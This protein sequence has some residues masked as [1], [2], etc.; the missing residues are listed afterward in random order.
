MS[1]PR[2]VSGIQPSWRLH[3]GNY[4]G[5]LKNLPH[6]QNS[7]QYE[8]FFFLA[9]LH[10]LTET[11]SPADKKRQIL[12]LAADLFAA[13]LDP[14]KATIFQQSAVESHTVLSWIFSTITPMG[15]LRRMTQFKD[16][17]GSADEDSIITN[18]GL[19]TYPVLM[20]SDILMYNPSF[21]PVGSDQLQHLE[22]TRTIARKFNTKFGELFIEPQPLLTATPRIMSLKD[23]TK[24]M[25]KSTPAGCLFV[26]DEPDVIMEKLKGAV[27][28]SG[29]EITYDPLTKPAIAN[30]IDIV[31]GVTGKTTAEVA[32]EYSG[33]SYSSFKTAVA[34]RIADA[35]AHHRTMKKELLADPDQMTAWLGAGAERAEEVAAMQLDKVKEVIGINLDN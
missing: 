23:P 32:T 27:T 22:L 5:V 12:E 26:D 3:V 17:S 25:S 11:Y 18:V 14:Q 21:V 2:L 20:A 15:E 9:D 8:C 31:S 4:L 19:F 16:K 7:G 30:I 35:F 10:S 24:K 29:T 13:G 33:M 34:E 28:D 1:L 6:L